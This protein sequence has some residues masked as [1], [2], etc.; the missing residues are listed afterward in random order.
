MTGNNRSNH[1]L[2]G[3]PK[4]VILAFYVITV[5]AI[6]FSIAYVITKLI[7]EP[8]YI[9][10][11]ISI[12]YIIL[13]VS[14]G[15]YLYV[16]NYIPSNLAHDFDA[17]KNAIA[18][19]EITTPEVFAEKLSVFICDFF[20][21]AFFDIEYSFIK[22]Q[23]S[24][25][26]YSNEKIEDE[27][28]DVLKEVLYTTKTTQDIFFR[29]RSKIQGVTYYIYIIPVWFGGV[30]Y[31]YIGVLT[32]QKLWKVYR[33]L[34]ADFENNFI[35]DQLIHVLNSFDLLY[36]FELFK[37]ID[38]FSKKI[39]K[40]EYDLIKEYQKDVL[41]VLVEKTMCLGGVFNSVYEKEWTFY[42]DKNL[43]SDPEKIIELCRKKELPEIPD[44]LRIKE[45]KKFDFLFIIPVKSKKTT[46]SIFLFDN[47]RIHFEKYK[48]FIM[49]VIDLKV[50]NDLENLKFRLNLPGNN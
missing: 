20:N 1:L 3:M 7:E 45:G 28:T 19:K 38:I 34:L 30:W 39:I 5:L 50:Y 11:F 13:A 37:N 49:E 48:S 2:Y 14:I 36:S 12:P 27:V 41:T 6:F 8:G 44:I 40:K 31:G 47:T 23:D 42:S 18:G 16:I 46:G 10:L 26:I 35:D 9:I 4:P 21:F 25:V 17:I 43:A 22:I 32:K 15:A 24:S 33:T 29:G